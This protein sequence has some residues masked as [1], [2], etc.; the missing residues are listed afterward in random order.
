MLYIQQS[1]SSDEK[2][3]AVGRF[4]WFYILG[5]V[6]YAVGGLVVSIGILWAG[7]WLSVHSAVGANFAS[8]PGNMYDAAW[9]DM[10]NRSG[11]YI[12]L[13]R[14]LNPVVRIAAFVAL[15]VGIY[16][17]VQRLIIMGTT[18]IAITTAR[19]VFKEGVI[20][21]NVGEMNIDRIESVH[22]YQSVFGRIFG[23]GVVEVRGMGIGEVTLP[24]LTDPVGLRRAIETARTYRADQHGNQN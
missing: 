3:V 19:L 15:I 10:V 4:H 11:G 20:A 8:L 22:V 7:V 5:A 9:T 18:E 13:I 23:Y 2:I 12:E 16:M 21:R 14:S 17:F 1:L 24:P 6:M